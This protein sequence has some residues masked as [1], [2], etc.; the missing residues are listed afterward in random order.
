MNKFSSDLTSQFAEELI[1]FKAFVKEAEATDEHTKGK[2][3]YYS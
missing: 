1:H 2:Q 3:S